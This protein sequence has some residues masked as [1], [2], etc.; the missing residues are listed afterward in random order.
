MDKQHL[1]IIVTANREQSPM[2]MVVKQASTQEVRDQVNIAKKT[3]NFYKVENYTRLDKSPLQNDRI[4]EQFKQEFNRAL[5]ANDERQVDAQAKR[6]EKQYQ[7]AK[8]PAIDF[9]KSSLLNQTARSQTKF[10]KRKNRWVVLTNDQLFY[11][12]VHQMLPYEVKT[13]DTQNQVKVPAVRVQPKPFPEIINRNCRSQRRLPMRN[14]EDVKDIVC[15]TKPKQYTHVPQHLKSESKVQPKSRNLGKLIAGFTQQ[16]VPKKLQFI[17][18]YSTP[19]T[20]AKQPKDAKVTEARNQELL[21]YEQASRQSKNTIQTLR[22][23]QHG[24]LR[25]RR[26]SKQESLRKTQKLLRSKTQERKQSTHYQLQ[27]QLPKQTT[28][29]SLHNDRCT[30]NEIGTNNADSLLHISDIQEQQ[31]LSARTLKKINFNAYLTQPKTA[32]KPLDN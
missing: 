27:G 13:H 17:N 11:K 1:N 29:D 12:Q 19:M 31:S 22:A 5:K 18:R 20:F 9:N 10:I 16:A 26:K 24:S 23:S 7:I 30:L 21:P 3:K 14:V 6:C 28:V 2:Q 32:E 25:E 15:E 4:H 8:N